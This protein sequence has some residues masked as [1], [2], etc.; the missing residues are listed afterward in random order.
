VIFGLLLNWPAIQERV[1]GEALPN[2]H[3][4]LRLGDDG[5]HVV[6]GEVQGST[7]VRSLTWVIKDMD[8]YTLLERN[9]AGEYDTKFFR[10]GQYKAYVSAW[11]GGQ[12]HPIS[13]E[14]VVDCPPGP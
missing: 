7:P 13:D 12:Y 6:R 4:E 8:G 14:I 11:Y 3:V 1:D 2:A 9:A 5:C 10:G